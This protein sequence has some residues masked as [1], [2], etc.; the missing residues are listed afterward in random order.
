MTFERGKRDAAVSRVM[1]VV[2]QIPRHASMLAASGRADIG[3][4]PVALAAG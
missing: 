3:E 4:V 1:R 2:E